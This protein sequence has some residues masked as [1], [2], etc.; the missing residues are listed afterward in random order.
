MGQVMDP[1]DQLVDAVRRIRKLVGAAAAPPRLEAARLAAEAP[2]A[3]ARRAEAR[4]R[5]A[6]AATRAGS[7]GWLPLIGPRVRAASAAATRDAAAAERVWADLRSRGM[8][9]SDLLTAARAAHVSAVRAEARAKRGDPLPSWLADRC[10]NLASRSRFLDETDGQQASKRAA[11]GPKVFALAREASGIVAAWDS[12][13]PPVAAPAVGASPQSDTPL[14]SR[15]YGPSRKGQFL[16]DLDGTGRTEEEPRIWLPVSAS[17]TRE[18]IERGARLDREAPRRGSQ[19]W[20]PVSERRKLE[21]FL[22][23]AFRAEPSR[24][25]FPPIRHNAVGQNLWSVFDQQSWNHIRT[26]AY[27]RA[28]HRCQICG[29]QGGGLWSRLVSDPEER[30]KGGPVDCH[31]VWEWEVT[32]ESK[33]VG[34]QRLSRLLV[35]CKDCHASFHES[36]V[37]WKAREVGIEDRAADHLKKLRMLINRCDGATLDAQLAGDR[38]RWEANKGVSAWV[39]DLAH[40]AKQDYMADHTM[41][42]K[43]GNRAGV[44][45]ALIGGIAFRT[46]DGTSFAASDARMLASGAPPRPVSRPASPRN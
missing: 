10:A 16:L 29:K 24:F 35:L 30:K 21:A 5:A 34:V 36:F 13:R 32:D 20:V 39:I 33:A 15:P 40:L 31:E 6:S 42:L 25:S 23:L 26:T 9:A 4:A 12:G 3:K 2:V 1:R 14:A 11:L 43:D 46:E 44:T 45:P 18:M 27:D 38:E 19:L 8:L 28:G 17:R 7:L 37:M 41:V 22:P